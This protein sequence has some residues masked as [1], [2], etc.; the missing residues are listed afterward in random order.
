MASF[1]LDEFAFDQLT[2]KS[3]YGGINSLSASNSDFVFCSNIS[4]SEQRP[5]NQQGLF[6]C[7]KLN[8][9]WL[10]D[11]DNPILHPQ[12]DDSELGNS[13]IQNTNAIIGKPCINNS[14]LS[15]S[16]YKCIKNGDLVDKLPNEDENEVSFIPCVLIYKKDDDGMFKFFQYLEY[17]EKYRLSTIS[18]Y[19][20]IRANAW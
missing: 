2:G 16:S 13:V 9:T 3:I 19:E 14:W 8:G 1:R 11:I 12:S 7:I 15:V 6:S 20:N 17:D 4:E 5:Y 10:L 18:E